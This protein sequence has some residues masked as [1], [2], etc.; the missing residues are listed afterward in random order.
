MDKVAED[1]APAQR[2]SSPF[3]RRAQHDAKRA[4][5]L[6]EAAR[7]FNGKG[8]RAT[9][10]QDV[11]TGLGLTKTSLYYYVRTKEELIFQC[12]EATLQRQHEILDRLDAA[13]SLSP[14]QRAEGFFKAQFDA[15][16]G[17][18]HKESM[19]AAALLEIA[20]LK[21]E[22]RQQI[23]D[24][25]I[26][27]FKRL[28]AYLRDAQEQGEIKM[29]E[30]TATTRAI[31]GALDWVFYWLHQLEADAREDAGTKSWDI[32]LRGIRSRTTDYASAPLELGHL[33]DRPAKGFDRQEQHRQKQEAFYK[34]GTWF[35]NKK[36]F[37]GASL[38]EIAEHLNVSK[39]AF[40][41]HI[42]NKEDLLYACYERSLGITQRIHAQVIASSHSSGLQKVDET[43]RLIFHAQNSEVGPLIRYNTI[44][45][46]PVPRR[47]EILE[48]TEGN[49]DEFN[50]F[51]QQGIADGSIRDV[52]PFLARSLLAGAI[53]AAMDIDLWRRVD[54]I[55]QAAQDY[56]DVFLTGLRPD[57]SD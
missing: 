16:L 12:Y 1:R 13:S 44:T 38:D 41:Y 24:A 2:D 10:L 53:N 28:R 42:K 9:T 5:I 14:L 6:S 29:R 17:V 3:N 15:W 8:S 18:L 27:M 22:R 31:L 39:G 57:N 50:T 19:P 49:N 46:L 45:A 21:A 35:F 51:I 34:T 33:V 23:E 37:S 30:A 56:F 4:A 25:Y 47:R 36:G 20:S 26:R 55:D 52:D 40:Y 7:L 48:A 54:D 32:L 43:A 11:A